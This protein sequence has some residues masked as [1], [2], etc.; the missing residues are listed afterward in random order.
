MSADTACSGYAMATG[1]RE[2]EIRRNNLV[3]AV[4]AALAA[5]GRTAEFNR[6]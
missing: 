2:H 6:G 5:I 4:G 3:L 1:K